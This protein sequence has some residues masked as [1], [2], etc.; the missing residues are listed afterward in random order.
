MKKR[1][2][3]ALFM[4]LLLLI[5]A[6]S[7]CGKDLTT[8]ISLESGEYYGEQEI[9]LS[10]AGTGT[11]YYT[12]DGSDPRDGGNEYNPE[13]PLK[14]NY[15]STLKA[16]T[17]EGSSKGK[18]VEATYTI[19]NM[20]QTDQTSGALMFTSY[21]RGTYQSG[22]SK[23]I[24]NQD[25]SLEWQNGSDAGSSP[26][27]ITMSSDEDPLKATLTYI[28]NDGKEAKY[29]IDAN[30]IWEDGSLVINGTTYQPVDEEDE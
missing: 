14:I 19:K 25:R 12:L 22:D 1:H 8:K 30:A 9:T 7:G 21:I 5:P 18:V 2:L 15:G 3:I 20:E 27:T 26:Y 29:D 13:M 4:I 17:K 6:L 11:I 28:N 24:F 10:N 16:Y 23:I